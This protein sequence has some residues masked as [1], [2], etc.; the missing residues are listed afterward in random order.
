MAENKITEAREKILETVALLEE[1]RGET[2]SV[3][4]LAKIKTPRSHDGSFQSLVV[5]FD[6]Q[7]MEAKEWIPVTVPVQ[8]SVALVVCAQDNILSEYAKEQT[9][10]TQ[11]LASKVT[12][13]VLKFVLEAKP[14]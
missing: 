9:H 14:L 6:P 2:N 7:T 1:N 13:P 4:V 11:L 3:I 12:D 8:N 5:V 10:D